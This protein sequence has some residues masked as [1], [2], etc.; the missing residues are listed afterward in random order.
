MVKNQTSNISNLL[1]PGSQR[2]FMRL[3]SKNQ[4]LISRCNRIIPRRVA[5]DLR[6][7]VGLQ[8]CLPSGSGDCQLGVRIDSLLTKKLTGGFDKWFIHVYPIIQKGFQNGFK[9]L[10]VDKVS[11]DCGVWKFCFRFFMGF[12]LG[13]HCLPRWSWNFVGSTDNQLVRSGWKV[14][15][16]HP[17]KLQWTDVLC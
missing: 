4:A 16:S 14:A 12:L 3:A 8:T 5:T 9:T 2:L 6:K 17:V 1:T 10:T 11:N 15:S 7:P 13:K